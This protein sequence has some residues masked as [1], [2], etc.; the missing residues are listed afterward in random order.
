MSTYE[1]VILLLATAALLYMFFRKAPLREFDPFP[2][3]GDKQDGTIMFW[4]FSSQVLAVVLILAAL[5]LMRV[6]SE[7]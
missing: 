7:R 6:I 2:R 3:F 1:A 5:H 4:T